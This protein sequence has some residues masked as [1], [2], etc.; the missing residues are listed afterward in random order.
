MSY[1]DIS[2]P[3]TSRQHLITVMNESRAEGATYY[4]YLD[5]RKALETFSEYRGGDC[6]R[7]TEYLFACMSPV[8]KDT[9]ELT[10]RQILCV[11]RMYARAAILGQKPFIG[12]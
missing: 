10:L 3:A 6:L 2:P 1:E 12:T 8:D 9:A 5:L 4:R 11:L 7:A